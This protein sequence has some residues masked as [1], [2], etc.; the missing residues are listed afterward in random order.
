MSESILLSRQSSNTKATHDDA[1]T[2][3][4]C[5]ASTSL[6]LS[7]CSCQASRNL[8]PQSTIQQG[9]GGSYLGCPGPACRCRG[10][11]VGDRVV[12]ARQIHSQPG[13]QEDQVAEQH[14]VLE[15]CPEAASF[16]ALHPRPQSLQRS[17][18]SGIIVHHAGCQ[19]LGPALYSGEHCVGSEASVGLS[20]HGNW[21]IIDATRHVRVCNG[22]CKPVRPQLCRTCALLKRWQLGSTDGQ[23]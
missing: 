23:A 13:S 16:A 14:L 11:Q 2:P 19:H 15:C 6:V 21:P 1:Q 12:E 18:Q 5:S 10:Q 17:R 8:Q 9:Q 3:A 4:R 22:V 7:C 20:W